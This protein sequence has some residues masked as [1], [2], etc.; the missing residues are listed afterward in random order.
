MTM[1]YW[2]LA[3]AI[4]LGA[5]VLPS[6][7]LQPPAPEVRLTIAPEYKQIDS[8]ATIT[9]IVVAENNTA[10]HI[11]NISFAFVNRDLV[12]TVAQPLPA[13]LAANS[14]A[15]GLYTT[16]VA[17]AGTSTLVGS[18]T[19]TLE[20]QQHVVV[21]QTEVTLQ[22]T[23]G[24]GRDLLLILIGALAGVLG[25]FLAEAG[26]GLLERRRQI[27]QQSTKALGLLIPTLAVCALAVEQNHK[28]PVELWDEVYFKEGLHA[29][30]ADRAGR[31]GQIE[32]LST[33]AQL[34][35]R[36]REY[37]TN[38]QYVDRPTLRQDLLDAQTLLQQLV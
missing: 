19:Y 15:T 12:P 28:A 13:D 7:L 30:L 22:G 16:Q 14:A 8:A 31:R 9:L 32:I 24:N 34:Y 27:E 26:K 6:A 29:A 25:G 23:A 17:R 10:Q 5:P 21:A 38:S 33:I 18:L 3:F 20:A 11:Q 37:N 4:T 2:M 35:A 1:R 36:L